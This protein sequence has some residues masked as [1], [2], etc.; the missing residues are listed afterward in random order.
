MMQSNQQPSDELIA[1][2][3]AGEA[4]A[5][6]RMEVESWAAESEENSMEIERLKKIFDAPTKTESH[7]FNTDAAWRKVKLRLTPDE[8]PVVELHPKKS[9]KRW[10]AL[11]AASVAVLAGLFV[12]FNKGNTAEIAYNQTI[13]SGNSPREVLLPDSSIVMLKPQSTLSYVA[14]FEGEERRL[15]LEGGAR[16]VVKKNPS[17]PFIVESRGAFVRVLGTTFLVENSIHKNETIVQVEEGKVLLSDELTNQPK[18]DLSAVVLEAGKSGSINDEHK[19]R[20][21][22][23]DPQ[24]AAFAFDQTIVF[25]N[26]DLK[27]AIGILSKFFGKEIQLSSES[28]ANCRLTA[29]FRHQSLQE[30]L[31]IIATTFNL[32]VKEE[33]GVR[34]IS[35]NGC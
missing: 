16:F 11:A 13:E 18:N 24:E 31:Q 12:I 27:S 32:E 33:N 26:T 34:I 2:F 23:I 5:T 10:I 21:Q 35:G 22:S 28:I 19:V 9:K 4:S 15:R 25:E 29:T 6:E 7:A 30:I 17:K 14:G 1:R 3:L 20:V 8:I